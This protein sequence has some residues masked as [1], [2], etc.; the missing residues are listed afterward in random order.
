MQYFWSVWGEVWCEHEVAL[1]VCAKRV[2]KRGVYFLLWC[3]FTVLLTMHRT[4][5]EHNTTQTQT[6]HETAVGD[7][8]LSETRNSLSNSS[9]AGVVCVWKEKNG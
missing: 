4:P 3:F 9:S 5:D 8:F 7:F 6:Q 1:V 2:V